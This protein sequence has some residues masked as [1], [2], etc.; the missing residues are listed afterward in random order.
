MTNSC[1]TTMECSAIGTF[2]ENRTGTFLY[3]KWIL[4]NMLFLEIVSCCRLLRLATDFYW[5]KKR[6]IRRMISLPV[7][8]Y[9]DWQR[10]LTNHR[11]AV[12]SSQLSFSSWNIFQQFK[13]IL[14][15]YG[16]FTSLYNVPST[17]MCLQTSWKTL[18]S[19]KSLNF[20][21][22]TFEQ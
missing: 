15:I 3:W 10:F 14:M 11:A 17:L 21:T 4:R 9:T 12:V 2:A 16:S 6:I 20:S 18:I 13:L 19:A 1:Q 22:V 5:Q 7:Q 8:R